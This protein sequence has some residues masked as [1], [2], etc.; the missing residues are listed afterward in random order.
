MDDR[1][2]YLFDLNG[3]LVLEEVLTPGEVAACNEAIDHHLGHPSMRS[4]ER[5]KPGG[6]DA[7]Q[8]TMRTDLAGMLTWPRPWCQPFRELLP[9]RRVMSCLLELLGDGFRLDH[10]YGTIMI[11]GAEGCALHGGRPKH[12]GFVPFYEFVNCRMRS[13]L[14]VVS[15]ALADCG[16]D[17]GGFV[18]I[19]GSHKSNYPLPGDMPRLEKD[20]AAVTQVPVKAGGV[21]IFTEA[22]VHGT[23]PWK[24]DHERRSLFYKYV[25]GS[26][27]HSHP[28]ACRTPEMTADTQNYRPEGVEQVLNEFTPVQQ[29]LLEPPYYPERPGIEKQ[30]DRQNDE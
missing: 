26:I 23:L 25:P 15:W 10:L 22:L 24:A 6:S 29:A 14:T 7:S 2:K 20:P 30:L 1:E 21:V 9:H 13:G 4:E 18:C 16:P 27:A 8:G 28:D 12:G 11:K 17:D 5:P 3:Y 19:P